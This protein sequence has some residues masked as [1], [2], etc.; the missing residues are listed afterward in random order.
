MKFQLNNNTNINNNPRN[1]SDENKIIEYINL[2]EKL[3]KIFIKMNDNSILLSPL[4]SLM[5]DLRGLFILIHWGIPYAYIP[6][7]IQSPLTQ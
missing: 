5:D 1:S 2:N 6:T 3:D 4:I 7:I